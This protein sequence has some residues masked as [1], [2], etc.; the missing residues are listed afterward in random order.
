V[1]AALAAAAV[2]AFWPTGGLLGQDLVLTN[3]VDL[4]PAAAATL[5][6]WCGHRS[7]DGHTGEDVIYRSFREVQIGVPV[8]SLTDGTVV[9]VQDG[10]YDFRFGPT[11]STFDNHLIVDAGDGRYFVYGH[12]RHGL[13]WR[14]GDTV[15]AGQQIAWGASSGNS[16]WPHLHLTALVGS[17]PHD[18]FTGPCNLAGGDAFAFDPRPTAPYLRDV[19]VSARPFTGRAA[20]P[21]DESKRTGT[22]VRGTRD[23]HVRLELGG[24]AGGTPTVQI[25]DRVDTPVLQPSPG[26]PAAYVLTERVH[27]DHLGAWPFRVTLNGVTLLEAKLRV[28]AKAAQAKNRKPFAVTTTVTTSGDVARCVVQTRL[29]YRDPD[30]DVVKYRYRWTAGGKVIR[31]VTSAMISDLVLVPAGTTPRCSVTPSD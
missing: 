28:V 11:V 7:Y 25:G 14:R 18:L 13:T 31:S 23:V 26:G 9:E 21:L 10:F 20:L 29:A 16:S 1:V 15:H 24:D 8:F 12:L 3:S 22:F 4:D 2:F 30:F 19:A 27:F 17:T 6:P 5:D